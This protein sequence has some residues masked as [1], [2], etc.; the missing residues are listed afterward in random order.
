MNH[1]RDLLDSLKNEATAPAA[2]KI[3]AHA[4]NKAADWCDVVGENAV[5]FSMGDISTAL[6]LQVIPEL[7]VL[8]YSTCWFE[9]EAHPPSTPGVAV[10]C[11]LLIHRYEDGRCIGLVWSRLK[12]EWRLIGEV[13]NFERTDKPMVKAGDADLFEATGMTAKA[14]MAF[15]SALHC[16]NVRREEHAPSEKLQRAREKRG[17]A[18]LFSHWTLQLDGGSDRGN[19]KGGTHASPRVHLRRGHPRQYSPG[20]WTWV[21]AHA[22]GNRAA[23]VVHKD[24]NAGPQL[25][26]ATARQNAGIER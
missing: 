18:P 16:S 2:A 12:R 26:A 5:C 4:L 13:S 17:K 10:T 23:G 11:G 9:A 25:L 19:D 24:Y 7:V 22:V 15:L 3:S 14:A 20:K 21:Q 8:P 6:D 1:L